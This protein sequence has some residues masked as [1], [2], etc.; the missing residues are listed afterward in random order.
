MVSLTAYPM[1]ETV[2]FYVL[3]NCFYIYVINML[4]YMQELSYDWCYSS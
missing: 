4:E 3:Y 1:N 2:E